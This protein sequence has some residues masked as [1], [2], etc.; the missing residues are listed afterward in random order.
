[1]LPRPPSRLRIFLVAGLVALA[2][3]ACGGAGARYASHLERAKRYLAEGNLDKA[4]IEFRNAL[5]VRPR[6]AEA[7]YLYGRVSEQ[8]GDL[9]Q[10]VGSYQAS[11]ELAPNDTPARASLGKLFVVA[12]AGEQ[13]LKTV[14]PALR[15]HPDDPD[16]L[17]V[18]GAAYHLLKQDDAARVDA[19][20][21]THLAPNNERAVA[22]LAGLYQTAGE[23]ERAVALLSEAVKRLPASR[24]LHQVLASIHLAANELDQAE[25]QVRILITLGPREL[26]SRL[27][28]AQLYSR[29]GKLDPAE[30]TLREAVRQLPGSNDAKLALAEF[31]ATRRT[32]V[33]GEQTLRSFIASDPDNADLRLGLAALLQNAG[34]VSEALVAYREVIRHSA[35]SPKELV[36]RDRMAAL[37]ASRGRLEEAQHQIEEVLK[38]NPRDDDALTLRANLALARSD[39]TSAISDLRAVLRDQPRSAPLQR[40][41]ARAYLAKGDRG[42]AEESLHAAVETAPNDPIAKSELAQLLEQTGRADEAVSLLE[43]AVHRFPEEAS[44]REQLVR[45]SLAKHDLPA[46][47]TAA[48]GLKTLKPQA[49]AGFYLSGVVASEQQ[50]VEDAE[51]DFKRALELQPGAFDAL[52]SLSRLEVS[53]GHPEQ[54]IA[55]LRGLLDR[56]PR[57][58]TLLN[59][60]AQ[61][62]LQGKDLERA[63]QTLNQ[64]L[65]ADPRSWGT[66]R[67]LAIVKVARNDP[68]AATKEYESALEIAPTQP[69]LTVELANLYE[70]QGR[71][72]EAVARYEALFKADAGS[73]Q[74]A[75]NNLAMLLVTYKKDQASLDRARDLTAEFVSSHS[76]SLLDTQGW[77][78]FKRGEYQNALAI[79]ERAAAGAGNSQVIRYHLAMAELQLGRRDRAR[80]DLQ[81]ALSGS[82][83]FAGA[84]DARAALASLGGHRS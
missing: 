4:S 15:Q 83:T 49:A 66:R 40:S 22:L 51:R 16:L 50:R 6:S 19:Q 42:L 61:T 36:A 7:L 5:Q 72:D 48:E 39:P 47:R 55:R 69:Q 38:R 63:E 44:F 41:L 17:I 82:P 46:A 30:Q 3:G 8:R 52:A 28:L 25:E 12:G 35:D 59:L 43:D 20:K 13:A 70:K 18:R 2:L 27:A 73:R 14:E 29:S 10:A 62:Y 78:M 77:V 84:D 53:H 68:I 31:L 26:P 34:A 79:L 80:S 32:R 1:M 60:L 58:V 76:S 24:D 64:A 56:D 67:N 74:L 11:I 65:A 9:R 81:T 71:I 57:N 45:A 37:E 54:A 33:Q 23:H 21:A 75:A